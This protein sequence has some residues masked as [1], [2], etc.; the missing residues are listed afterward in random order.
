MTCSKWPRY[1][2][3]CTSPSFH[4]PAPPSRPCSPISC[5]CMLH[6]HHAIR[7]IFIVEF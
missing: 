6:I 4:S 5:L 1:F 7:N 2:I 3:M